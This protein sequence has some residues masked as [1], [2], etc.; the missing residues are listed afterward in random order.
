MGPSAPGLGEPARQLSDAVVSWGAE[1]LAFPKEATCLL[2]VHHH[3]QRP[4]RFT[5]LIAN[6]VFDIGPVPRR[7]A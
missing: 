1:S 7:L 3:H 6:L 4:G 2:L 5:P